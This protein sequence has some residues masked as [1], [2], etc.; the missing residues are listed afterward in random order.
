MGIPKDD[1]PRL[2]EK[3]F[4]VEA[5]K[6]MAP[7]SGLGLSLVKQVVETVHGGEVSIISEVGR[8]STFAITLPLYN[9]D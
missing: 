6:K 1:L 3:F 9:G 8:G 2:F 7:G 5:N 4:S